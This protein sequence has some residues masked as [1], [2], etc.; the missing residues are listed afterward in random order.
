MDLSAAGAPFETVLS[1][2]V[3]VDPLIETRRKL[4]RELRVLNRP[5]SPPPLLLPL[6]RSP[7]GKAPKKTQK[8]DPEARAGMPLASKTINV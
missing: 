3:F 1:S 7:S 5:P 2:V 4:F 6:E 8:V